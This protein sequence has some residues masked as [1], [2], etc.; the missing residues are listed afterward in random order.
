M[1]VLGI[2]THHTLSPQP[3]RRRVHLGRIA[4]D[5]CGLFVPCKD[6]T[7][8]LPGYCVATGAVHLW[9]AAA[10]PL[11]GGFGSED[12]QTET[13]EALAEENGCEEDDENQQ[14]REFAVAD[15]L[16]CRKGQVC[17]AKSASCQGR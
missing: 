9:Q 15:V 13:N 7:D 17:Q 8:G 6:Y 2:V 5:S 10:P 1:E 4:L 16:G 3:I 11:F 12:E 14:D